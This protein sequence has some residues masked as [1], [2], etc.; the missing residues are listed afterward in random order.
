MYRIPQTTRVGDGGV[1]RDKRS[2]SQRSLFLSW[3]AKSWWM[4]KENVAKR[5]I[6]KV[7]GKGIIQ[8]TPMRVCKNEVGNEARK[9]DQSLGSRGKG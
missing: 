9:E 6:T 4:G 1:G 5:T 7:G 8:K 2:R 3:R